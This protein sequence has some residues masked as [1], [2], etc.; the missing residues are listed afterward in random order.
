MS[1][2]WSKTIGDLTERPG[3][4]GDWG[5]YN[6]DGL[7]LIEYMLWCQDLNME[8]VLAVFA[9]LYLDKTILPRAQ[10]APFVQDTLD[11]LEF[12]MGNASTTYGARRIALGYKDP[13]PIRYVEVGNEDGLNN[14]LPSVQ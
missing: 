9:G 3:R 6:T 12:L 13:F 7:G 2:K 14:G 8:P 10:L 1:W 4:S 11:E 5:Y